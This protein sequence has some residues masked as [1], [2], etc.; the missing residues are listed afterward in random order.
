VILI[1][2]SLWNKSITTELALGAQNFLKNREIDCEIIKVPGA[3]EIPLAIQWAFDRAKH[4]QST[5][6]GAVA[7]GVVLKGDTYHFEIVANESARALTEI[8]L[9]LRLPIGNAILACYEVQQA[10][11][12]AGGKLGNKGLEAAAAIVDMI[13]LKKTRNY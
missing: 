13:D 8:S 6:E 5:F 4:E 3:L 10:L 11:D 12:R 7:C 1:V 9:A 2:Q